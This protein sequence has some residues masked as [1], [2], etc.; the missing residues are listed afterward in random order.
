MYGLGAALSYTLAQRYTETDM[1]KRIGK[2][3]FK[4]DKIRHS[5]DPRE[6][7]KSLYAGIYHLD[8]Q[9]RKK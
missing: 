1:H 2:T 7:L 5:F 8:T 6:Y 9:E 3:S 4:K